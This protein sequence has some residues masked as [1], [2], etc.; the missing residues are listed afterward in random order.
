MHI[1]QS[2]YNSEILWQ[3]I[4]YSCDNCILGYNNKL[5]TFFDV[6]RNTEQIKGTYADALASKKR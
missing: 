4:K 2:L 3:Y 1:S 6:G 5:N